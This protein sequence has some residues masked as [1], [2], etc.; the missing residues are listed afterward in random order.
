MDRLTVKTGSLTSGRHVL[1]IFAVDPYFAFSKWVLY[2]QK[3]K[4]NAMGG[5]TGNPQL[6]ERM[7]LR[8]KLFYGKIQAA[9]RD[10]IYGA[11]MPVGNS[12]ADEDTGRKALSRSR[13]LAVFSRTD[14]ALDSGTG[15]GTHKGKSCIKNRYHAFGHPL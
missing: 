11:R 10:V 5:M 3:R 7:D 1:R 2:T 15:S 6:P 9:P 4:E 13:N 8:E 14:M 12:L